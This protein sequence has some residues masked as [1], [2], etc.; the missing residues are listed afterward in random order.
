ME[1]TQLKI[2]GE[3]RQSKRNVE[4]ELKECD[5]SCCTKH[6]KKVKFYVELTIHPDVNAKLE[7]SEDP[8]EPEVRILTRVARIHSRGAVRFR[9]WKL[10]VAGLVKANEA[11]G[12]MQRVHE[13]DFFGSEAVP[14]DQL[15]TLTQKQ[16]V[17]K[18]L[19]AGKSS[20]KAKVTITKK[21]APAPP[22]DSK[23]KAFKPAGVTA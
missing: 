22:E 18:L 9:L 7:A 8:N 3:R 20:E 12:V 1:S 23:F 19:L 15:G 2:H 11:L 6:S 17:T 16:F 4:V 14:M 21:P 5:K 10:V 13:Y